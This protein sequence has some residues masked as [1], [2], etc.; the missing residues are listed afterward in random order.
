MQKIIVI[1]V[2]GS[3]KSTL[4]K[5]LSTTFGYPYIQLDKLFWKKNWQGSSDEELF[6]HVNFYRLRS[7]RDARSFLDSLNKGRR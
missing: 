5:K 1:G 6:S 4:A 7:R 3:G 2:T